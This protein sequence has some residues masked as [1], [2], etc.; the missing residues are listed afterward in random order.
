MNLRFPSF[1]IARAMAIS[2]LAFIAFF[3][4]APL[5]LA[6]TVSGTV[7]NGTTGK[8]AAGAEVILIQLQGGMQP[9]ANTKTDAKGRYSFDNPGLGAG[10]PMLIRVVYGGV[11]YHEPVPPGKTTADVQ[12]FEPTDKP[13]AFTV[14]NHAVIVQQMCIRDSSIWTVL[15]EPGLSI[16]QGGLPVIR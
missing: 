1:R 7:T 6:G 16:L 4:A 2:F 12:V 14:T 9:V 8:P 13:S 3:A 10:A 15:L 11:N 5:A